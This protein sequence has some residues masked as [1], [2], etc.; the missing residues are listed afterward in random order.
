MAEVFCK[1]AGSEYLRPDLELFPV[2]GDACEYKRVVCGNDDLR[3]CDADPASDFGG[4]FSAL[5]NWDD[6][7]KVPVWISGGGG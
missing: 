4:T 1:R 7:W 5:L 2:A 3:D 6:A